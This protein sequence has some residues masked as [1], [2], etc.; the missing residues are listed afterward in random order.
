M[1]NRDHGYYTLSACIGW[2]NYIY[3]IPYSIVPSEYNFLTLPV[4]DHRRLAQSI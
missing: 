3:F 2:W 1:E 4:D